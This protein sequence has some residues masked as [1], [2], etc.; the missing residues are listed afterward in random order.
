MCGSCCKVKDEV[1]IAWSDMDP[2]QKKHRIKKLWKKAK[3][4]LLF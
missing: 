4:I 3:R 1:N 2:L